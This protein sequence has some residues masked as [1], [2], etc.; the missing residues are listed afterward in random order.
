MDYTVLIGFEFIMVHSGVFMAIIPRKFSLYILV[1]FYGLFALA[2]NASVTDNQILILFALVVLNRM[3]F[4][5]TDVPP[6]VK[7]RSILF[8]VLAAFIYFVSI[9]VMLPLGGFLPEF[10]LDYSYYTE[11][12]EPLEHSVG[13]DFEREPHRLI[14]FGAVFFLLLAILEL[15]SGTMAKRMKSS[16]GIFLLFSDFEPMSK[17]F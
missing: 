3:R 14:A 15:F 13:G 5:F 1:P 9:M 12:M 4:A 10:G 6:I 2:F 8:S 17:R 7:V 16:G 11:F